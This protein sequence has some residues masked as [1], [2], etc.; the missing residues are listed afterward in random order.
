MSTTPTPAERAP[1]EKASDKRDA[2]IAHVPGDEDPFG[3][4]ET[5]ESPADGPAHPGVQLVG[6]GASDVVRLEDVV[7]GAHRGVSLL[8]GRQ[9]HRGPLARPMTHRGTAFAAPRTTS[10]VLTSVRRFRPL[11]L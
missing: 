2:R 5:G 3:P 11:G 6:H 9:S 1:A 7:E 8:G 10:L 4:Y